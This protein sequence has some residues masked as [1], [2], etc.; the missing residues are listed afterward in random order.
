[1]SLHLC[2]DIQMDGLEFGINN[3]KTWL[4]PALSQQLRLV[5]M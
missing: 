3:I 1:M 5:V 2:Y 4:H